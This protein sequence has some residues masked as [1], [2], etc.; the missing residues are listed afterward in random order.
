MYSYC[1]LIDYFCVLVNGIP[2]L[3]PIAADCGLAA[4]E[5]PTRS[6]AKSI[7]RVIAYRLSLAH[8]DG[9]DNR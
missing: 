4:S 1:I 2:L 9:G 3:V 6:G 5:G 7:D 8:V